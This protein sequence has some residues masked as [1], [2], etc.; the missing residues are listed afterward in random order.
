MRMDSMNT[1]T[2]EEASKLACPLKFTKGFGNCNGK[3]CMG[4]NWQTDRFRRFQRSTDNFIDEPPRPDNVPASWTWQPYD[5]EE[6]NQSGW[7]QLTDEADATRLGYCGFMGK[8][9]TYE[10]DDS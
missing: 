7:L 10:N 4:W 2:P 3:N 5:H 8:R 6:G 9:N 1:M